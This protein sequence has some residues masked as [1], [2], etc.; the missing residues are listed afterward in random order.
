MGRSQHANFLLGEFT[1]TIPQHANS[2]GVYGGVVGDGN[3][4]SA[5]TSNLNNTMLRG[6]Q[7]TDSEGVAQSQFVFP[8]HY[9]GRATHV[10]VLTHIGGTILAYGTY[11]GG[12]ITR[13]GQLFFD[14]SL[15]N[16]INSNVSPYT[17]NT[18]A[19]VNNSADRVFAAETAS[20][21]DPVFDYVLWGDSVTDGIFAW[22]SF[23]INP[24]ASYTASAAAA[25]GANGGVKEN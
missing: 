1:L 2:T 23:G 15:I 20:N 5:D 18:I 14:Q 4:S 6:L 3:G 12:S 11:K 25:Y 24:S 10:H 9:A 17:K 19:I 21:S 7:P 16:E 22:I 13:A 8:G